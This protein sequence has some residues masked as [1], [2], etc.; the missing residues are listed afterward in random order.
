[1]SRKLVID[2][3]IWL[4]GEGKAPSRLV[5]QSDGK[6]CCL[7]IYLLACG[8]PHAS[9]LNA[10]VP[11]DVT[12][13]I[14]EEAHWLFSDDASSLMIYNDALIREGEEVAVVEAIREKHITE[15]FAKHR[16]DVTFV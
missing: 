2:R 4:R 1:M 14:P 6:Q 10:A 8:M 16:I 12:R 3:K 9:L 13:E 5:R 15:L 11:I 7:G